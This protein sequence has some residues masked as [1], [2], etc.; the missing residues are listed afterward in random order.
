MKGIKHGISNVT[1]IL[2]NIGRMYNQMKTYRKIN[3]KLTVFELKTIK[4]W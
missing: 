2:N 4:P 1:Y 3:G